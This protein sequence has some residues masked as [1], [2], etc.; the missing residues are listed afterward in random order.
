[1]HLNT[2]KEK[3]KNKSLCGYIASIAHSHSLSPSYRIKYCV[4]GR[5]SLRPRPGA[6]ISL[7]IVLFVESM[8]K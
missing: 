7:R 5:L 8:Q 6:I 2:E 1:M 3:K 4:G